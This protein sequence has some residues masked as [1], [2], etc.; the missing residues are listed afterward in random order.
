MMIR[1]LL[2]YSLIVFALLFAGCEDERVPRDYPRVRTLPV[3]N[4]TEEG[5]LFSAEVYEPGNVEITEHGFT[6]SSGNPDVTHNDRIFLGALA[7]VGQ[8][9]SEIMTALEAG[10]KYK[11]AAFIRAGEY[12][13]YGNTVEFESLGSQGPVITGFTPERA[14]CGDTVLIRGRNFSWVRESN[15]VFFNET[16][17]TL[18]GQVTDTTIL[19]VVPYSLMVPE[20]TISLEIAGNRTT[21]I[22]RKLLV[23]LPVVE[24]ITPVSAHWGDTVEITI[25]NLKPWLNVRILFGPVILVPVVPF[26]G[27]KVS[28]VV[29]WETSF[30]ETQVKIAASEA[31]FAAPAPFLLLPPVIDRISPPDGL[32]SDNVM[33]HGSFNRL[34]QYSSV[35]FGQHDAQILYASSDTLIV[36]VPESLN[37][38][39]AEVVY[40]YL[41]LSSAP[42]QFSLKPPEITSV[43]PMNGPTG[44]YVTIGCKNIKYP[45]VSV[46]LN[47]VEIGWTA[48]G[49]SNYNNTYLESL[50]KGSING[51]AYFRVTV[52]GQSDM[53]DQPFMVENP[54]VVS[55]YPHTAIP[56]DTITI[57]AE[58][59][60]EY[61]TY[62]N[63]QSNMPVLSRSGNEFR[64]VYPDCNHVSGPIYVTCFNNSQISKIPSEDYLTQRQPVISSVTPMEARYLDEVTVRG[65]NFS[66]IKEYNHL[67]VNGVEAELTS[68]SRD[69][70][71][72]RMPLLP[73]GD[74]PVELQLGGYRLNAGQQLTSLSAWERLPDLPFNNRESFVMDFNGDILVAA[75]PDYQST[76]ID[77]TIY[78]YDPDIGKFNSLGSKISCIATYYGLVVKG[79]KAY[80]SRING[81]LPPVLDVFDRNT[82][83]LSRVSDLPASGGYSYWLMDGDSILLAGLGTSHWKFSLSSGRWTRLNDLPGQTNQGH[84]FTIDGRNYIITPQARLYEYDAADDSWILRSWPSFSWL[85]HEHSETVVCNNKAYVCFGYV[86]SAQIA[87]YDPVTDTWERVDG[88]AFPV[89]RENVLAFS[90]GNRLFLGGGNNYLDFWSFDTLFE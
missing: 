80:I 33:L 31:Q 65:E 35:R 83:T 87:V 74:Y 43:S 32:W 49:G 88:I 47:D 84:V 75:S 54:Y 51:P 16:N 36:K 14:L 61:Y 12:T 25:R 45:F 20:Q 62:F 6:W 71:K 7:G 77:R 70:L 38:T 37:V 44:T 18:C 55:F 52:C 34:K 76:V 27:Q 13:V 19:A 86:G 68:C 67:S 1:D 48:M 39:P 56:G 63:L 15:K 82:L 81:T 3:T 11:V 10:L 26:D 41:R 79:D 21:F 4:I 24:E 42:A 40:S 23:D 78:R 90:L 9:S 85:F 30:P 28:F 29:P 60:T 46:F 8:Y 72:F 53:W 17:A 22:D 73:A 89:P 66:L 58:N 69:E 5:A 50:I 64:V 2:K 59:F 57:V